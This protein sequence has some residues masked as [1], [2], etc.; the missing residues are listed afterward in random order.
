MSDVELANAPGNPGVISPRSRLP[1]ELLTTSAVALL[2]N[3]NGERNNGGDPTVNGA[4]S[5]I[6]IQCLLEPVTHSSA[7]GDKDG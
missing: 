7:F 2:M 1:H 6:L 4:S 3:G 5:G